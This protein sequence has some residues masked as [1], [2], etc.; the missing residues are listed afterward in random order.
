[1]GDWPDF[2]GHAIVFRNDDRRLF[3]AEHQ[4]RSATATLVRNVH[5][6][7]IGNFY[8]SMQTVA[9]RDRE[10]G[11][12]R[13]ESDSAIEAESA[14]RIRDTLRAVPN[15]ILIVRECRV[16]C[17]RRRQRSP[18]YGLMID[19]GGD[20]R[21]LT[22]QESIAIVVGELSCAAEWRQTF[23]LRHECASGVVI[24]K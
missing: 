12:L 17:E 24:R 20:S 8:V 22:G 19:A 16:S 11:H 6:S 4:R 7:I 3:I 5:S 18:A 23:E 2:P 15:A 9:V 14:T 21:S 10:N 13:T 1:M